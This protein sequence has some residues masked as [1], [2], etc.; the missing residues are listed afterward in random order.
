MN[1]EQAL[2]IIK[3]VEQQFVCA[4]KDHDAIKQAIA[5]I[6]AALAAKDAK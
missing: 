5:V 1:T 4:G 2:I 3:Q 6:E